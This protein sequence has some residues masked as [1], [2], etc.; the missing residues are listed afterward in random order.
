MNKD[1]ILHSKRFASSST[2][3]KFYTA[4]MYKD[5]KKST[6]CSCPGWCR[7][8]ATDGSRTC[9]HTVALCEEFGEGTPRTASYIQT[10]L[11]EEPYNG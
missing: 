2:A 8:V 9:K 1:A 11:A 3:G 4:L 7:R 5:A 6:S 10:A